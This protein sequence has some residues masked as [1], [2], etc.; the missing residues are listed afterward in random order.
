MAEDFVCPLKAQVDVEEPQPVTVCDD[1][2]VIFGQTFKGLRTY[3]IVLL[4]T[5]VFSYLAIKT[6]DIVSM[7]DLALMACSFMF[8]TKVAARK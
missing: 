7:K 4:L 6:N 8:G 1:E 2:L 3:S 5:I